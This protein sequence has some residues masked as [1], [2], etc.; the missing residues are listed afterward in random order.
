MI[1]VYKDVYYETVSASGISGCIE[2]VPTPMGYMEESL[3]KDKI[4]KEQSN[5][6]R[7]YYTSTTK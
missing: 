4:D 5:E 3:Y 1:N 7:E 6:R 2:L